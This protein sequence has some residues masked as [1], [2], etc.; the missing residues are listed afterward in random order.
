MN[1]E[2]RICVIKI[3]P[4]NV[5]QPLTGLAVCLG[6][7]SMNFLLMNIMYPLLPNDINT[8]TFL[9]RTRA[10]GHCFDVKI[11]S[12]ESMKGMFIPMNSCDMKT[13]EQVKGYINNTFMP[14]FYSAVCG[15]NRFDVEQEQLPL[16]K[17]KT[18]IHTVSN[19]SEAIYYQEDIVTI[20]S[21]VLK[22]RDVTFSDWIDHA[23][24]NIYSLFQPGKVPPYAI[25]RCRICLDKL[26]LEDQINYAAFVIEQKRY[27][28]LQ[29]EGFLDDIRGK[30]LLTPTEHRNL[31]S[32]I[33]HSA[34]K[35]DADE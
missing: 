29:D 25:V 31:R 13:E 10:C 15:T 28:L 33:R 21:M 22:P 4:R 23:D 32:I 35:R 30:K 20:V 6:G 34:T 17:D 16:L 9:S 1:Q 18:Q 2:D 24:G 19:W 27:E 7:F 11:E 5:Q 12:R 26:Y 3:L 14:S 8:T